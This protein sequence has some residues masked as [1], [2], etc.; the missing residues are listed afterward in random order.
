MDN[1]NPPSAFS[2]VNNLRGFHAGN[3][4]HGRYNQLIT[5][6]IRRFADA[7]IDRLMQLCEEEESIFEICNLPIPE[8]Q[9][10]WQDQ[11]NG[12]ENY[13]EGGEESVFVQLCRCL[14]SQEAPVS[15]LT[16]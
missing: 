12:S 15:E 14:N 8:L 1:N 2:F 9:Q 13:N 5:I 3:D 11:L 10:Y 7:N 6:T 16:P 4:E